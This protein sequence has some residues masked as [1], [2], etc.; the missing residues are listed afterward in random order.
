MQHQGRLFLRDI[1]LID[2]QLLGLSEGSHIAFCKKVRNLAAYTA[3]QNLYKWKFADVDLLS[4]TALL[5]N[6]CYELMNPET[7]SHLIFALRSFSLL[8]ATSE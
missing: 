4:D 6:M 3:R 8:F 5:P 7:V 1:L 2:Y